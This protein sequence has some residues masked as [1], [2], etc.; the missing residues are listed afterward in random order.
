[1]VKRKMSNY[2]VKRS[3]HRGGLTIQRPAV[4]VIAAPA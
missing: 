4:T 3:Y 1:V 2:T